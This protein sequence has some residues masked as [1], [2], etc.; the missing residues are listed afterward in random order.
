MRIGE[1]RG[2]FARLRAYRERKSGGSTGKV[3]ERIEGKA[4]R[5]TEAFPEE[6]RTGGAERNRGACEHTE[7]RNR[8]F[9]KEEGAE[10][11]EGSI[12]VALEKSVAKRG[13]QEESGDSGEGGAR[14]GC[15]E[16]RAP[17]RG[18]EYGDAPVLLG[19]GARIVTRTP[20]DKPKTIADA[21]EMAE[22]YFRRTRL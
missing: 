17:L 15:G 16:G 14:P 21:G 9:A 6:F 10:V 2:I 18:T 13:E 22:L 3:A 11:G 20:S 8:V 5:S 4:R 19:N 12:P 7:A 1:K